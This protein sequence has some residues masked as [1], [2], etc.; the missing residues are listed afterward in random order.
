MD[1][2]GRSTKSMTP[3]DDRDRTIAELLERIAV[4]TDEVKA[5]N[6]LIAELR[7]PKQ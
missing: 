2:Q 4:L 5:G 1:A 6:I 3:P 7:N